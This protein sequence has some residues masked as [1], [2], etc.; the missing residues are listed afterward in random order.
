[1]K[2]DQ[3]NNDRTL[4]MAL[5]GPTELA[6]KLGFTDGGRRVHNWLK[7]G[8]PASIKIMYPAIFLKK[9]T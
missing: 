3:I 9:K 5:G 6:K 7:R 8:I 2:Q 4:I 1:M